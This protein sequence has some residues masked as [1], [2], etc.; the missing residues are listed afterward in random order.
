MLELFAHR[1]RR[2][3]GLD[4]ARRCWPT[5]APSSNA[6]GSPT[7]RC[8]RRDI[9]DLPLADHSANAI[10][11]HQVLHFLADPQR[12]I[13]EAARVLARGGRLLIVDF[14]P[15]SL[16]FLR[17]QFAHER[18][19]FA[20]SLVGQWLADNG[21]ELIERR[22]LAPEGGEAEG[23]LTVSVWLAGRPAG[24]PK[25]RTPADGRSNVEAIA[26]TKPARRRKPPAGRRRYQRFLRVLPAQDGEDGG[27]A[28]GPQF[29]GSSR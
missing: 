28:C 22:D 4:R 26:G 23:K 16:E 7:R 2:G 20:G 13:R 15:H 1:Y 9:Y 21:L 3:L 29:G 11:M 24:Q 18:L 14:A 12:A 17:E 27:D 5:R 8:D 6:A 25:A 19:G 10:I